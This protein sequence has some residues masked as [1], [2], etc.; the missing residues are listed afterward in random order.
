MAEE[1][2]LDEITQYPTLVG[3]MSPVQ[4]EEQNVASIQS[5]EQNVAPIQS[6]EQNFKPI[7]QYRTTT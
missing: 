4:S 5:E 6:E 7:R 2:K 1:N 3:L